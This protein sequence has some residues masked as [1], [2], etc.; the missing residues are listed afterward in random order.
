MILLRQI[1]TTAAAGSLDAVERGRDFGYGED[2]VRGKLGSA[3]LPRLLPGQGTTTLC[4]E[5]AAKLVAAGTDLAGIGLVVVCTQ[6]PD[7]HGIPHTSARVQAA[8]DLGEDCA[9]FDLSLGC[10]GYVY[11]LSVVKAFMEAHKIPRGLFFTAD[12]YSR[13]LDPEDSGTAL[14]FGDA[15]TVTLL[16]EGGEGWH[17]A[18]A[19]FA[20]RG[21]GGHALHNDDGPLHMD[22]R[23]VFNFALTAVPPQV[24]ALLS[25]NG[26]QTHDVDLYA[27]HQGSRYMVEKLAARLGLTAGQAPVELEGVGNCVSSTLPWV[28]HR[29]LRALRVK[30]AVISGFGAGL[31]YASALLRHVSPPPTNLANTDEQHPC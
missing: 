3:R 14:L 9:C 21:Q 10:S 30:L 24:R 18:D 26:L 7:G 31:S 27:L 16:E 6:N 1:A 8:L 15:A 23:E 29:H 22:G 25:R 17:L 4:L 13:I 11:G 20:T 19:L 12:P 2:F 28:L 5:A